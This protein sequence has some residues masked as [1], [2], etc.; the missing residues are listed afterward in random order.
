[1]TTMT[2]NT[3]AGYTS[4]AAD[5]SPRQSFAARLAALQARQEQSPHLKDAARPVA[6]FA[7]P[8]VPVTVMGWLFVFV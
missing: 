4:F 7:L 6:R 1:M 5:R 3:A 2:F 8:A